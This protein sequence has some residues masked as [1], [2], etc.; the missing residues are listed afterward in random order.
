MEWTYSMYPNLYTWSNYSFLQPQ[1]K[2]E[3]KKERCRCLEG[4]LVPQFH[5]ARQ[6]TKP[7]AQI[8]STGNLCFSSFTLQLSNIVPH[9]QV[10][11]HH[12]SMPKKNERQNFKS[13]NIRDIIN[14]QYY[15]LTYLD[16]MVTSCSY[17]MTNGRK[18]LLCG[19]PT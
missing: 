5:I 15:K 3:N 11:E 7:K 8:W 18:W 9:C 19:T 13:S 16:G 1:N 10:K 6:I 2:E 14:N 12:W 4:F 17:E